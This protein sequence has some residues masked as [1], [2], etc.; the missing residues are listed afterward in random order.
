MSK[1]DNLKFFKQTKSRADHVCSSCG[2]KINRGDIYYPEEI[3]DKF[4]HSLHR[5]KLCK[6]CYQDINESK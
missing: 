4:L 2:K 6:K 3:K 5:K 1:Y